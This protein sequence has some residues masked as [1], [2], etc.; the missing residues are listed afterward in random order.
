[1]SSQNNEAASGV[2][3]ERIVRGDCAYIAQPTNRNRYVLEGVPPEIEVLYTWKVKSNTSGSEVKHFFVNITTRVKKW[4]LP[5]VSLASIQEALK[6][7]QNNGDEAKGGEDEAVQPVNPVEELV[8]TSNTSSVV[9]DEQP[10]ASSRVVLPC[11]STSG[12]PLSESDDD[13]T[14]PQHN[15]QQQGPS[16]APPP[17]ETVSDEKKS[18]I[19]A[20]EP[21][22]VDVEALTKECAALHAEL[23][24]KDKMIDKLERDMER[25]RAS[26]VAEVTRL[27]MMLNSRVRA[28][29]ASVERAAASLLSPPRPGSTEVDK[30]RDELSSLKQKYDSDVEA[31]RESL[32][33]PKKAKTTADD[34]HN[35]N[36]NNNNNDDDDDGSRREAFEAKCYQ[37][38]QS[39]LEYE[40]RIMQEYVTE[41]C[42]K[43]NTAL[44][45]AKQ[46]LEDQ[47]C[48]LEA[49]AAQIEVELRMEY[50]TKEDQLRAE[51]EAK[52][53]ELQA[54]I[55]HARESCRKKQ[56]ECDR[57]LALER[58][59]LE[60]EIEDLRNHIRES[61][62][63]DALDTKH[64]EHAD[65]MAR[66]A[67]IENRL[68]NARS[69]E[70][71]LHSLL[72]DAEASWARMQ[73]EWHSECAPLRDALSTAVRQVHASA[74]STERMRREGVAML[75][76]Q[77]QHTLEQ[78]IALVKV[79]AAAT[80]EAVEANMRKDSGATETALRL[81]KEEITAL[82]A[83]KDR[84]VAAVE[85][86]MSE[87]DE[88]HR[89]QL[90]AWESEAASE[91]QQ[92]EATIRRLRES[93]SE[94]R[95]EARASEARLQH[96]LDNTQRALREVQEAVARERSELNKKE[97][98][99]AVELEK[100]R[101][102][103]HAARRDVELNAVSQQ[104]EIDARVRHE[105]EAFKRRFLE[106]RDTSTLGLPAPQ[107]A[108]ALASSSLSPRGPYR[109]AEPV[110]GASSSVVSSVRSTTPNGT[111]TSARARRLREWS[112]STLSSPQ[113]Q[114]LQHNNN[115]NSSTPMPQPH[116]ARPQ[117]VAPFYH[118]T[119]STFNNLSAR[120]A[121]GNAQQL[122]GS[123]KSTT[124]TSSPTP[125]MSAAS[126]RSN[127]EA[128]MRLQNLT[129][130]LK[131]RLEQR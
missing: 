75:E 65:F 80:M 52:K 111:V 46:S 54:E 70:S 105:V 19:P 64:S 30:L 27:E 73:S 21:Q 86:R 81:A 24:E 113:P 3:P 72:D 42:E 82:R 44:N 34:D 33:T 95:D 22:G 101:S 131:S 127:S 31:L 10:A 37:N 117:P 32:D 90:E 112:S 91:R 48:V 118:S 98:D 36:D 83:E 68:S 79:E 39:Y 94:E 41:Y 26:H 35:D 116:T 115:N 114:L 124:S 16:P 74:A 109:G 20:P 6:E 61:S 40:R 126:S 7:Q 107:H 106:L 13:R 4:E 23:D 15:K 63:R 9:E 17:P 66:N 28:A 50:R 1:M 119:P 47:A 97:C 77:L 56:Q 62:A 103:L 51:V 71:Q 121:P 53:G 102:E 55:D 18:D 49:N 96:D 5:I 85:E 99:T 43:C 60:T 89:R 92:L 108:A 125:V 8:S 104:D 11:P 59:K 128:Y 67:D 57:A 38:A 2:F 87:K 100:M 76:V 110:L 14:P 123:M 88:E 69:L 29:S 129:E 45:D 58:R 122:D 130:R 93:L 12:P 78:H 84:A 120:N 25:Q